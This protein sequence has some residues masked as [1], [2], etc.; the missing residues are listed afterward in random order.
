MKNDPKFSRWLKT[1]CLREGREPVLSKAAEFAIVAVFLNPDDVTI[2]FLPS[3]AKGNRSF[4][5]LTVSL[6][7]L[8]DPLVCRNYRFFANRS[9][10]VSDTIPSQSPKVP[11]MYSGAVVFPFRIIPFRHF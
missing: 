2:R 11:K 8:E 3:R 5:S 1:E 6:A 4:K 9:W 7:T 10:S